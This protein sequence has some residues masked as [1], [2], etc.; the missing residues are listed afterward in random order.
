[1]KN[2]KTLFGVLFAVVIAAVFMAL[3]YPA[4]NTIKAQQNLEQIMLFHS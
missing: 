2:T 1:M 4:K 3:S